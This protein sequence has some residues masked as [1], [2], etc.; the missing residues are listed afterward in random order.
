MTSRKTKNKII[1]FVF[2]TGSICM[3]IVAILIHIILY[4][5]FFKIYNFVLNKKQIA[6][7]PPND[8]IFQN[9]ELEETFSNSIQNQEIQQEPLSQ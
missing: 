7:S 6:Q 4:K 2:Y 8:N 9:N 1:N 5:T 3:I